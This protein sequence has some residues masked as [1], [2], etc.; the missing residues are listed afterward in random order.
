MLCARINDHFAR[1]RPRFCL[2]TTKDREL[3]RARERARVIMIV[4]ID[5]TLA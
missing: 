2:M 5:G 3:M 1:A 4:A